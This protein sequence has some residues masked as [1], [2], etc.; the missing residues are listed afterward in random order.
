MQIDFYTNDSR[1]LRDLWY[2]KSSIWN[3]NVIF[4]EKNSSDVNSYKFQTQLREREEVE[5]HNEQKKIHDEWELTLRKAR[6]RTVKS[7][8]ECVC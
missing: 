5:I 4:R 8:M 1:Y 6:E 3:S 2:L 7:F